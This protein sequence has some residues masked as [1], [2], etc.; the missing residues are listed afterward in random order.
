VTAT[1]LRAK[2][3]VV[4]TI[5]A[6]NQAIRLISERSPEWRLIVVADKK[7]PTPWEH[8]T[9]TF[10]SLDDQLTVGN[11]FAAL[12]PFNHY[13][14]KNIGYLAAIRDGAEVIAETDDDN[15]PYDSW[16]QS[17]SRSVRARP[18]QHRGWENVYRHF[19]THRVWPRGFP[20]ELVVSSFHA[21]GLGDEAMYD[22]PIQQYLADDNPDVDAIYRLVSA[23]PLKF[24]PGSVVLEGG[25]Y[26]PFNS[27]NT[28][29]W[30]EAYELLYLP[31]F[32]SFR[33]TD[34]WRAFV[35]IAC[36]HQLGKA[37]HFGSATMYQVRNEHNLLRDFADEVPGYLNNAR[38][39]SLLAALP[40]VAG[41]ENVAT[42]MR[43]CYEALVADGI[44][45]DKELPLLEAWLGDVK[46]LRST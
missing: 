7:T 22:C 36:L 14:R 23:E 2:A 21:N 4:T 39:M 3:I 27:Q 26:C 13:S 33:M 19:S 30:P 18:V 41:E 37:L 42:N 32:V 44:V 20:L 43:C 1:N 9:A 38:I 5:N 10:L 25:T 35:A 45:P 17:V 28:V 40:L 29:W 12:C 8:R 34:I 31:S 11:R 15:L 16:L 6:P 24:T 46:A